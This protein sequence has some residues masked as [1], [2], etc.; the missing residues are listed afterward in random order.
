MY[1]RSAV[2]GIALFCW[3]GGLLD[4]D[5]FPVCHPFGNAYFSVLTQLFSKTAVGKLW[6]EFH[7]FTTELELISVL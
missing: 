2:A 4:L 5:G 1:Y 7:Q 3:L 6:Y